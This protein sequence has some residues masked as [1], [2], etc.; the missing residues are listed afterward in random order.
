MM[1]HEKSGK[2]KNICNYIFKEIKHYTLFL[3]KKIINFEANIVKTFS[4]LSA[5]QYV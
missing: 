1:V 4:P 2:T 5:V 3:D